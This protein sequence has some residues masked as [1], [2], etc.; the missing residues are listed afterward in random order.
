[1]LYTAM[2]GF[3]QK[4]KDWLMVM[5]NPRGTTVLVEGIPEEFRS[6]DE[7]KT[8]FNKIFDKPVVKEAIIVKYTAEL[9]K[10][11]KARD[12]LQTQIQQLKH[13]LSTTP[14]DAA[15]KAALQT[16]EEELKTAEKE[17]VEAQKDVL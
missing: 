4:R 13:T 16:K 9:L 6:D 15:A 10:K 11:I 14:D 17:V 12:A 2:R 1:M 3:L 8:Y 5:P 7:L